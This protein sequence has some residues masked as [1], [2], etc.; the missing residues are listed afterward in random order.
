MV[1]GVVP[2]R[3]RAVSA[4]IARLDAE[5]LVH[6]LARLHLV[7]QVL[8][9]AH[10][11]RSAFVQRELRVD[12]LA[13]VLD[14]PVDA[15]EAAAFFVRREGENEIAVRSK[16]LLLQANQIR[17]DDRRHRFVVARA[18]AVEESVLLEE[19]ERIERPV[20]APRLDDVEVREEEEWLARA[21]PAIARDQIVLARI[22]A[23]EH[24]VRRGESGGLQPRGHGLGGL[25]DAAGRRVGRV[26]LDELLENLARTA[27]RR[28][29]LGG[30]EQCSRARGHDREAPPFH[31]ADYRCCYHRYGWLPS[32]GPFRASC[33]TATIRCGAPS[34]YTT[35]RA[36]L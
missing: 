21:G 33:S 10:L 13:A 30:D 11:T 9:F 12:E 25:G 31:A 7:D 4:R 26:D 24:H 15:V 14:Q 8:A 16:A 6:L 34:R 3:A 19:D 1:D 35:G 2:N 5:I 18:A 32:P 20:L 29:G 22:G 17:R 27:V 36:R 23:R 28:R